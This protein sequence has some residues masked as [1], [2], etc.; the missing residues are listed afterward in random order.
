MNSKQT[1]VRVANLDC[2]HDAANIERGLA[3]FAGIVGLKVYP[4]S[5]KVT[6]TYDPDQTNPSALKQKLDAL[7]FPPQKGMEM[8]EQ[9]KPWRNPKVITSVISGVLL[10]VGWLIGLAG[11]PV[12]I[13]TI[14]FIAA[15]LIGGY[16]FGREAIEEL[17]FE[18]KIGIEL[19][20]LVAA[21]VASAMGE[22]LEGA[23]LVFLYSISEAAEG[24]TEE[25]TR[26]AIKA[27]MDLAPKVALVR[28]DGREQEIPVEELLVGDVF[29]VKP[30]Q[31]MATDGEVLVGSS[32]VNQAPVTGESVPVEKQVGDPVF[33]GSINGEGALE[34]RATKTFADNTIARIIIMVEEAQEKKGKSQRFIERFGERY[35]PIVLLVGIL[36]AIVPPLFFSADWVSWITRATVF[37]VA[38]APCAL[39]IS[40]PITLV[41]SLGTGARNG[42]LIKGGIYIEELAKVKVIA[43]DKT[44]TLTRGEPEVTDVVLFRQDPDRLTNSQ[45]EFLAV[46]AGIERRSGHPLA[47]AIVRHVET[48]GVQPAELADF[49]SLTGAGA[50]ARLDGRTVYVGSPDLFHSKLGISLEHAWDDINHLQ[51]EGK[52]VVLLGDEQA[53]W[54]MIAIRD[55][56]RPNAQK[57]IDAMHAAG[58]EKVVMLT[59][60]NERT[61]QA[62][63]HEL[64]ID[65]VYADLKPEDKA[66]KVRELTARYGHVAMVGDGVNDAPA[67]AEATVGVAMGAAG[68]D[69]AL[70]TADIALMADDLEKLAYALR[71]AKRNQSIVNQNLVLSAVVIS[72][73]IIGAVGGWFTLPIAVLAHE[74]SEF[75][76]IGSG[77]RMLKN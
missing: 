2:E 35:S 64:G 65:E 77:L 72:V 1:E 26:A 15:I 41:A 29:I 10:L 38:A 19:L 43:M 66:V 34:V 67:L 28:R 20:M 36:I 68:T 59:G 7:G 33:A 32:S 70:E 58:A 71:L 30:G 6:L 47:Q 62:I 27:L 69:V 4:K 75:V 14:I 25:K 73:L 40:I 37:I 3:G 60:D 39:V 45:Q 16:Y 61:A 5:A 54:G 23:M 57:A 18:R 31:T 13:S 50:S 17:I 51:G 55:N 53:P 52:T 49:R 46:A 24:Y 63:A 74:I 56:I 12:L 9:V 48:Q 22:V 21:V 44:G 11:A 8:A 42:V 76:V